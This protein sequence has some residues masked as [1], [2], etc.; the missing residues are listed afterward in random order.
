M[1][2]WIG[3][4][5]CERGIY[6]SERW[7]GLTLENSKMEEVN[8][9]TTTGLA[10]SAVKG[11]GFWDGSGWARGGH[12][13]A[14]DWAAEGGKRVARAHR[15]WS[16]SPIGLDPTRY[17]EF[18]IRCTVVQLQVAT[19]S[20]RLIWQRLA[21]GCYR[22]PTP[23]WQVFF[24]K[25]LVPNLELTEE[26]FI[27]RIMGMSSFILLCHLSSICFRTYSLYS[28]FQ[29]LQNLTIPIILAN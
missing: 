25:N 9:P 14:A 4:R 28:Y 23:T 7:T 19:R 15:R 8:T 2:V 18:Q 16:V 6:I 27:L 11:D 26:S 22:T 20:C 12:V 5:G 1:L 29:P 13:A 3:A 21:A 24:F 17:S 10:W